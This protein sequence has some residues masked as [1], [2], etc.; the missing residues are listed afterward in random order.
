M[1]HALKGHC[2]ENGNA[3][4]W[5]SVPLNAAP[6]P[7]F[8]LRS[9]SASIY[10]KEEFRTQAVVSSSAAPKLLTTPHLRSTPPPQG[11][12]AGR[13]LPSLPPQHEVPA[14]VSLAWPALLALL[15]PARHPPLPSL[16]C[17]PAAPLSSAAPPSTSP[18][19][20]GEAE[21]ACACAPIHLALSVGRGRP[22]PPQFPTR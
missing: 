22:A 7:A 4:P 6:S 8:L 12:A 5:A 19:A 3:W 15:L 20:K 17:A 11:P 21:E 9:G 2:W 18:V 1:G 14:P 13:S 16:L 10:K